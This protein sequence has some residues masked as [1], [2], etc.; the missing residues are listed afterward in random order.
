[1]PLRPKY[2]CHVSLQ[3]KH[4]YALNISVFELLYLGGYW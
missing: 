3:P 4:C 2:F 1:M